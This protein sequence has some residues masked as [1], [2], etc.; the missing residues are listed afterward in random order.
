MHSKLKCIIQNFY[1]FGRLF[2]QGQS[3][4]KCCL[5]FYIIENY[6]LV[7]LTLNFLLSFKI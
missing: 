3:L 2:Q 1:T 7:S 6:L 4:W 5:L